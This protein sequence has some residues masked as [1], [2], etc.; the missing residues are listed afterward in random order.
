MCLSVALLSF[1]RKPKVDFFSAILGPTNARLRCWIQQK[2][3]W[4]NQRGPN[5]QKPIGF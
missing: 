2:N 4:K 3:R 5:M 1:L